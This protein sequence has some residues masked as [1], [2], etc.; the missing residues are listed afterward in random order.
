M[1]YATPS[2]SLSICAVVDVGA[3]QYD[4]R[5]QR[6]IYPGVQDGRR[7]RS[8]SGRSD[9]ERV[10]STSNY[11]QGHIIRCRWQ[12]LIFPSGL[13]FGSA[14]IPIVPGLYT[15]VRRLI[16]YKLRVRCRRL[17]RGRGGSV[18]RSCHT[19]HID[20]VMPRTNVVRSLIRSVL[21]VS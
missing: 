4:S 5:A 17:R 18:R 12:A 16:K 3:R 10:E 15:A 13:S 14:A 7:V 19:H 8:A 9:G 1:N 20:D 6:S 21:A 2:S 11:H